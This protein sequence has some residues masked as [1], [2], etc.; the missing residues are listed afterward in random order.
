MKNYSGYIVGDEDDFEWRKYKT[1]GA[2]NTYEKTVKNPIRQVKRQIYVLARYLEY[3]GVRVWV[4]GYAVLLQG[5]SPVE[6]EYILR[7]VKDIDR[8]IHA[9][10]RTRLDAKTTAEIARLLSMSS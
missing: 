2:G 1:T 6:S 10:D 5:N 4:K 8:A 7:G 9:P 3:C